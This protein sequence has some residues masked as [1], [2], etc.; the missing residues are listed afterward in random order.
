MT[1]PAYDFSPSLALLLLGATLALLPLLW[2][3]WRHRRG[4]GAIA[5]AET[6]S[7]PPTFLRMPV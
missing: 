1:S 5:R 4:E 3:G 7:R 6:P 2:V